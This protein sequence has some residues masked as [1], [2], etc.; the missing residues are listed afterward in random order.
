MGGYVDIP[1]PPADRDSLPRAVPAAI[2]AGDSWF[3]IIRR[4]SERIANLTAENDRPPGRTPGKTGTQEAAQPMVWDRALVLELLRSER[5]GEAMEILRALPPESNAD[6]D[7]QLL[8]AVLLTNSGELPEAEKVCQRLLQLDE[9][10]AG[11]HYLIALG[12][13][14]AGDRD[15]AVEHDQTAVYLDSAFAMPHLHIGLMAKRFAE[16]QTAQ[17]ELGCA[18]ALLDREDPSR[19]LLFGGGFTREALAAFCRAELRACGNGA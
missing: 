11:A 12:R 13:E 19:I 15:A 10:N 3:D 18:L 2:E 5:F 7:A 1:Q 6:A 14:H 9:L 8:L 17:R 4:A 16:M